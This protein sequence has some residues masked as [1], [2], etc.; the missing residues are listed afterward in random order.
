MNLARWYPGATRRGV[1]P[2]HRRT[3]VEAGGQGIP[4]PPE[5]LFVFNLSTLAPTAASPSS[6]LYLIVSR[7]APDPLYQIVAEVELLLKHAQVRL[8]LVFHLDG[9]LGLGGEHLHRAAF[10]G[11]QVGL[12]Q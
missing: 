8:G 5:E 7:P 12:L 3:A 9:A 4:P 2:D 11:E 1:P 6:L 10:R